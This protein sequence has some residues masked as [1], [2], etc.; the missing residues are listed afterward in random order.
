RQI[1]SALAAAHSKRIVHRDLKPDNIMLVPD[2]ETPE[3]ERVKIFDFGIAKLRV[4]SMGPSRNVGLEFRTETGIIMGTPTHMAPE[5]CRGVSD[6]TGKADVYALGVILYQCLIGHPPFMA[7]SAGELL[8]MHLR[9]QPTPLRKL[10]KTIT[11]EVAEFVQRMLEKEPADRPEMLEVVAQLEALGAQRSRGSASEAYLASVTRGDKGKNKAV[12]TL[13]PVVGQ[14]IGTVTQRRFAVAIVIAACLVMVAAV[15]LFGD[16]DRAERLA[17][18]PESA[19]GPQVKWWIDSE[20]SGAQVIR[21]DSGVVLGETPYHIERPRDHGE[22]KLRI[23]IPGYGDQTVIADAAGNLSTTVY[24]NKLGTAAIAR[25]GAERTVA[26]SPPVPAGTIEWK[27]ASRPSG[28]TVIRAET[29]ETLGVTPLS[30]TQPAGSG[31]TKVLLRAAGY[32]DQPVILDQ[33]SPMD[34]KYVLKSLKQRPKRPSAEEEI[35]L[36]DSDEG[37]G[38]TSPAAPDSRNPAK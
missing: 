15:L 35:P 31:T 22:I 36:F 2:P 3:G 24:L 25:E 26:K 30:L 28:A 38:G 6:V 11:D 32:A 34:M 5:Q 17:A 1:A 33:S 13:P 4:D 27:I 37:S 10:D 23:R 9:D 21:D 12:Q 29:G 7:S 20:P 19:S 14:T 16:L 18:H 8:S